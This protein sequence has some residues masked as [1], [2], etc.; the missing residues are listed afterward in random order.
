MVCEKEVN[1]TN[2]PRL[3]GFGR[4]DWDAVAPKEINTTGMSA[5]A[6]EAMRRGGANLAAAGS[7]IGS[8]SRWILNSNFGTRRRLPQTVS[9]STSRRFSGGD[10]GMIDDRMGILNSAS[11]MLYNQGMA[12]NLTS[13]DMNKGQEAILA[14]LKVIAQNTGF[15]NDL[16]QF[17][18]AVLAGGGS[19]NTSKP[20][21]KPL[22][23][24]KKHM[25]GGTT[26]EVDAS[27]RAAVMTLA[28]IARG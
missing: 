12:G 16:F 20:E 10:S 9:V 8:G 15:I 19:K 18:K 14:I 26:G 17:L 27:L 5:T 11:N 1:I 13:A 2:N 22:G 23:S 4:P 28:A 3:T 24:N 6:I 7:G 25:G 21:P